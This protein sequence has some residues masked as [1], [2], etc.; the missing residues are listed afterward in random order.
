PFQV[1]NDANVIERAYLCPEGLPYGA[2]LEVTPRQADILPGQAAI[3]HC[4]LTLDEDIIRPGCSNDQ[5]FKLTAWRIAEDADERWGSC[6]YFLRPRVRTKVRLVRASWYESQLSVYGVLSLD[7]DQP[8]QLAA[9][10]PLHVRLRLETVDATGSA[11]QWTTV[12]VQAGGAFVLTRADFKGLDPSELRIQA[13]FDRTDVL[14]S[15]RSDVFTV[16]H[17]VAP[18]I[19]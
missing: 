11:K 14:A 2:T 8:V 13:W 19:R 4:R 5:G 6:F 17:G 16:K 9:Q 15:S 18:V 7:T 3:F 1:H 10:L 12:P